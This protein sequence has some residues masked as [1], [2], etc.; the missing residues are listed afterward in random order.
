MSR[1]KGEVKVDREEL[2][3]YTEKVGNVRGTVFC[4]LT[5]VQFLLD[6]EL[7]EDIRDS[8]GSLEED[9]KK[10]EGD[11]KTKAYVL[12]YANSVME[13]REHIL[14]IVRHLV[15]EVLKEADELDEVGT[16]FGHNII[17]LEEAQGCPPLT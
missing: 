12:H 1:Y 5:A 14:W 16:H 10:L 2:H 11:D 8:F 6:K 17:K 4:N 7:G 9:I 13:D 15:E 3:G